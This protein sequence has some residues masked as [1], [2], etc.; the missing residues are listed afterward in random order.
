MRNNVQATH[1]DSAVRDAFGQGGH[2]ATETRNT[3]TSEGH[4]KVGCFSQYITVSLEPGRGLTRGNLTAPL[5]SGLRLFARRTVSASFGLGLN[6]RPHHAISINVRR[7]PN[8]VNSLLSCP[9]SF[10]P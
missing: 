8:L 2:S 9:Q 10:R 6:I 5:K 3:S 1:N 7:L 4:S